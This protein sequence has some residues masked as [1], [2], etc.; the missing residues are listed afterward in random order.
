MDSRAKVTLLE[1]WTENINGSTNE[2]IFKVHF[3]GLNLKLQLQIV[4][5]CFVLKVFICRITKQTY[6]A[7]DSNVKLQK[8]YDC[9][10]FE[11]KNS[12]FYFQED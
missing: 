8:A 5:T 12:L 11:E 9:K 6:H 1:Q 10:M 2:Q 4:I 7:F 3:A